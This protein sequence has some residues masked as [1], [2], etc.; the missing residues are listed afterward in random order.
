MSKP[1]DLNDVRT[2]AAVAKAGTLTEATKELGQ[3]ASTVSRSITRL[4]DHLGTLLVRRSQRGL[5]LTD[6]GK[7]YLISCKTALKS[8]RDSTNL[9]RNTADILERTL[10]G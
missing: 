10:A 3:P 9:S 1:L 4:E 6:A 2:F 5:T 7:R 8:L